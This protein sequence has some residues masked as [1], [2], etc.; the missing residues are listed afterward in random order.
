[1]S[2]PTGPLEVAVVADQEYLWCSCGLSENQPWCD[3]S[4][5]SGCAPIRFTAAVSGMYVMCGCKRSENPPYCFGNC[6]GDP[7]AR[8]AVWAIE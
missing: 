2:T 5:R 7:R 1:M 4:H 8:S 3:Q 6:R